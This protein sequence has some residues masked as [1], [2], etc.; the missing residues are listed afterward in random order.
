MMTHKCTFSNMPNI[1]QMFYVRHIF[2]KP[3]PDLNMPV[4]DDGF[5]RQALLLQKSRR[6][7]QPLFFHRIRIGDLVTLQSIDFNIR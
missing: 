7:Y 6:S 4:R 1:K 3:L 5:Y 2:S